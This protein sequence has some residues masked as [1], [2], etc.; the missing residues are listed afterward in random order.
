MFL[1]DIE[2]LAENV[3]DDLMPNFPKPIPS[4]MSV[5]GSTE[6]VRYA[7]AR[8]LHRRTGSKVKQNPN[9][10]YRINLPFFVRKY[11]PD[12]C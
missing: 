8:E 6:G 10:F 12:C 7:V 4:V 11:D 9:G 5:S 2:K 1:M 3:V